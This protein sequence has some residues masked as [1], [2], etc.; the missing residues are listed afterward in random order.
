MSDV[1]DEL[2]QTKIMDRAREIDRVASVL[3]HA[4]YDYYRAVHVSQA[5]G[6]DALRDA[7]LEFAH[8]HDAYMLEQVVAGGSQ[9]VGSFSVVYDG[10]H[11]LETV[12]RVG[13]NTF[14]LWCAYHSRRLC[15]DPTQ[16]YPI[17]TWDPSEGWVIDLSEID[18]CPGLPRTEAD[19]AEAD[20]CMASW[21]IL[22]V[23]SPSDFLG[24]PDKEAV[25]VGS[26]Y[27]GR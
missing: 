27:R 24:L 12:A 19:P 17:M 21:V 11:R 1:S 26:I 3:R 15:P 9:L 22:E 14:M 23:P 10:F 18:Y 6:W 2:Y 7:A 5:T 4:A 8:V 13:T 25:G 20:R 16:E